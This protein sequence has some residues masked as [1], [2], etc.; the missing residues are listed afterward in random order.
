MVW[1]IVVRIFDLLLSMNSSTFFEEGEGLQAHSTLLAVDYSI[2]KCVQM[3][4]L[5]LN[6]ALS[7]LFSIT[8]SEHVR[9]SNRLSI[10]SKKRA[11]STRHENRRRTERMAERRSGDDIDS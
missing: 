8:S 4:I 11:Q 1:T 5:A 9:P 3:L 7:M 2:S 6:T 10:G